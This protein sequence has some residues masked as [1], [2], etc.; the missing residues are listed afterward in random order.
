[1]SSRPAAAWRKVSPPCHW[2][3][4]EWRSLARTNPAGRG[5]PACVY[6]NV[7]FATTVGDLQGDVF[8]RRSTL[9]RFPT[10]T[11]RRRWHC[12][13]PIQSSGAVLAAWLLICKRIS[14][15]CKLGWRIVLGDWHHGLPSVVHH[16][17]NLAVIAK[18]VKVARVSGDL[19]NGPRHAI[20]PL[21][22]VLATPKYRR[23]E[24]IFAYR[25]RA[26]GLALG[27]AGKKA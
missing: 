25:F 9:E 27:L 10:V 26:G 21:G 5:K 6:E 20:F 24:N 16:A 22:A 8:I 2:R 15:G 18:R 23:A 4:R 19:N 12:T 11:F 13:F 17:K 7:R 3:D 1:M 14:C